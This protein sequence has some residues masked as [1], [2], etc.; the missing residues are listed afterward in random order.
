MKSKYWIIGIV[1]VI[2]AVGGII[3]ARSGNNSNSNSTSTTSTQSTDTTGQTAPQS[4]ATIT[5]TGSGF[6]PNTITVK[7]GD[8]IT[9]MNA[10]SR[11]LQ[12]DSNPHPAH[13][14]NTELN[15]G[16]VAAGQSATFTI[17]KTGTWGYHNHLEA[18]QTGSITVQ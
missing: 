14:D 9:I 8:T 6:S 2:L 4:A 18:S 3:V 10:S 1:V 15:V 12:L 16:A 11:S 7:A 17:S 13:T 5:Y